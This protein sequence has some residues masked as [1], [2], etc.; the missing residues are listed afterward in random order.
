MRYFCMGNALVVGLIE[1]MGRR[2]LEI[3]KEDVKE[4]ANNRTVKLVLEGEFEFIVI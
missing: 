1:R 4:I 2:I 3:E